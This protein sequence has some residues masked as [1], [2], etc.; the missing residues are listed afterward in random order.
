ML[1]EGNIEE[2]LLI[3]LEK[4]RAMKTGE[5]MNISLIK[6][7]SDEVVGN[8]CDG[9]FNLLKKDGKK[10]IGVRVNFYLI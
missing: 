6:T 3:K 2:Y 9:F 8:F 7:S 1:D 5:E 10:T 4:L